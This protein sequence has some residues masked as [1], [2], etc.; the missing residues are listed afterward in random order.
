MLGPHDEPSSPVL[1]GIE[2]VSLWRIAALLLFT[3]LI[4]AIGL[5][6]YR[7]AMEPIT[8][9]Q[10]SPVTSGSTD[11]LATFPSELL[12][13]A[14]AVSTALAPTPTPVPPTPTYTMLPTPRP[15]GICLT[16]TPRGSVCSQPM[17][18]LPT[19]TPIQSCPVKPEEVCVHPGGAVRFLT[20]TPSPTPFGR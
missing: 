3:M 2:R 11:P 7:W 12:V 18:P 8:L 10:P 9:V 15:A 20:P 16:S 1:L 19:P 4:V 5:A 6:L 14:A 17:P 13:M